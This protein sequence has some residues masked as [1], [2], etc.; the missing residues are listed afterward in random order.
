MG[1]FQAVQGNIQKYTVGGSGKSDAEM[2]AAI[3][4]IVSGAVTSN[5]VVDVFGA[6]GLARP[7]ISVLYDEFLET[8]RRSEHKNLQLE[9]LKKLLNDEIQAQSGR[10]VVVARKFSE[11]LERTLLKKHGYPPDKQEGAVGVVV[12][13]AERLCKDW[14]ARP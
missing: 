9:L 5:G 13:Q 12:E 4:Q 11:M 7:D 2:H 1:F 8:V 6:A 3:R 14:A 10:N